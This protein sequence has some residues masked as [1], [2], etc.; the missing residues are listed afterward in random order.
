MLVDSAA[1]V[2]VTEATVVITEPRTD[3]T[4]VRCGSIFRVSEQF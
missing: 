4:H 1:V 2:G 3:R